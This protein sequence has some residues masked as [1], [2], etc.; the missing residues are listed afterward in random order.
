M[1]LEEDSNQLFDESCQTKG[2]THEELDEESK[3]NLVVDED[4]GN[5]HLN[6][7]FGAYSSKKKTKKKKNRFVATHSDSEDV[8]DLAENKKESD[9][10]QEAF[11]KKPKKKTKA[12]KQNKLKDPSQTKLQFDQEPLL[13]ETKDEPE[14]NGCKEQ[15]NND[16][17]SLRC[18]VCNNVFP[19][20][21]KLFEHLKATNHSVYVD[22]SDSRGKKKSKKK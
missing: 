7:T 15:L 10:D 19:S 14:K 12:A 1:L 13:K 8:L 18:A 5:D 3:S 20:K 17:P 4:D 22:N 21:N 6:E 9:S 2:E 11:A 16:Q